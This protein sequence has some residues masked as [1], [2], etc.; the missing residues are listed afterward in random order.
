VLNCNNIEWKPV[1][2]FEGVYL[3]SNTGL[4]K[5]VERAVR[6]TKKS[7]RIV[8]EQLMS[9][10]PTGT[11]DYLYTRLNKNGKCKIAAV[12]RLVAEAFVPNPDNKPMV[13]HIDGNKLNNHFSNLEWVTC[14]ENH[15]HAFNIGLRSIEKLAK[16]MI[17]T[18]YNS[19]SKYHNVSWDSTR[20]KWIGGIKDKC[21]RVCSKRFNT[22]EEAAL[23]VNQ[24]IDKFNLDRPKNIIT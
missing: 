3:I 11:V 14:S 20:K 21:K 24:M 6:N 16:V 5:S 17:G 18:K 23:Y 22:E 9:A 15:K 10:H 7:I 4:V 2:G 19:V 8:K 1:T 13:N 12:H